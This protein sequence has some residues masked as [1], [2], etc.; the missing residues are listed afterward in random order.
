MLY[1]NEPLFL[2]LLTSTRVVFFPKT[3]KVLQRNTKDFFPLSYRLSTW[4]RFLLHISHC[5]CY[6]AS[7]NI[8]TFSPLSN[9]GW[10]HKYGKRMLP[11]FLPPFKNR[12]ILRHSHGFFSFVYSPALYGNIY[13]DCEIADMCARRKYTFS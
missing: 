3:T 11:S 7:I 2:H 12:V 5:V 9:R 8:N 6:V 10:L 13:H 4:P 1:F